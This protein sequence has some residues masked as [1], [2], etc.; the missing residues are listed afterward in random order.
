[1]IRPSYAAGLDQVSTR[2]VK[3]HPQDPLLRFLG[4]IDRLLYTAASAFILCV[5][6]LSSG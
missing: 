4:R 1:M 3:A 5:I 2:T 6:A